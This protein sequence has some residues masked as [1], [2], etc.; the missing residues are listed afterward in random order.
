[1]TKEIGG[2]LMSKNDLNFSATFTANEYRTLMEPYGPVYIMKLALKEYLDDGSVT[3]D[4]KNLLLNLPSG[5]VI[6]FKYEV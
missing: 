5:G 3:W 4:A 1:M 2:K 6:K